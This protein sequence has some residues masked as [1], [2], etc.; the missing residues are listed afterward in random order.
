MPIGTIWELG[1]GDEVITTVREAGYDWP[2]TY[3]D[4]EDPAAFDR[5]RAYFPRSD[6][7]WPDTP[8]FDALYNEILVKGGFWLR[9]TASGE[10]LN[11]VSPINHD[12][13][14]SVVWFRTH[15]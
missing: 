6:E 3:G 10:R 9:D 12:G 8:E 13:S 5:F 7:E 2:W 4:L 11:N 1:L 14:G 15:H